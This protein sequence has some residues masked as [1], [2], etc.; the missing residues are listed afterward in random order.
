MPQQ[1]EPAASENCLDTEALIHDFTE[2]FGDI[3]NQFQDN[4]PG[5]LYLPDNM[6]S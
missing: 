1:V 3:V 5:L 2:G 4:R 6:T